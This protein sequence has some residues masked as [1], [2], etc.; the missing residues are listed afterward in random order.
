[1]RTLNRWVLVLLVGGCASGD[2]IGIDAD[3]NPFVFEPPELD[4]V[5]PDAVS[6][7]D[8]IL[9]FGAEFLPPERGSMYLELEG[10]Y[11]DE[12]GGVTEYKGGIPLRYKNPSLAELRFDRLFFL[13]NQDR[14]GVFKGRARVVSNLEYSDDV[15][16][17]EQVSADLPITLRIL[18]SIVVSRLRPATVDFC[19]EVTRGTNAN[20]ELDIAVRAIGMGHA[21]PDA[22]W[23]AKMTFQA[24]QASVLYIR[25]AEYTFWPPS[26]LDLANRDVTVPPDPGSHTLS[27]QI[28]NGSTLLINPLRY[29]TR[30]TVSPP[31]TIGQNL[32]DKVVLARFATGPIEQLGEH[33]APMVFE[34]RT[35]DGTSVRR[36]IDY[37]VYSEITLATYDGRAKLMRAYHPQ[38]VDGCTHGGDTGRELAYS[39]SRSESRSRTMGFRAD[40]NVS[41]SLGLSTSLPVINQLIAQFAPPSITWTQTFGVDISETATSETSSGK[42][43]SIHVLPTYWAAPYRQTEEVEREVDVIYHNP[44]GVSGVVGQATLTDWR[45]KTAI[46]QS[47]SCP[48]PPPPDMKPSVN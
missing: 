29:Q 2:P 26:Q 10:S 24:P 17:K 34:F 16:V 35:W 32:H 21:T 15:E 12:L 22:P 3:G 4:R 18:P 1:M 6:L 43:L 27:F 13:T 31:I 46:P 33:A 7:G 42:N 38:Q 11:L 48:P 5:A 23:S 37:R 40:V 25:E 39:E 14:I 47:P 30:A 19:A 20:H 41:L 9:V 8:S 28:N 45:W 36:V 44:C